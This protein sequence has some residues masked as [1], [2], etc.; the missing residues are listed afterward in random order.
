M[1]GKA[2]SPGYIRRPKVFP[3]IL[4]QKT[5]GCSV[6]AGMWSGGWGVTFGSGAEIRSISVLAAPQSSIL[7]PF[8]Y[9]FIIFIIFNSF[10]FIS[11]SPLPLFF[12]CTHPLPQDNV[13]SLEARR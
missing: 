12:Y 3:G 7:C 9:L 10:F 13:S 5:A 6:Q 8:F 2:A 4:H 1:G 11:R